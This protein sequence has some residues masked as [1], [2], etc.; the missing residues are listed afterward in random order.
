MPHEP[1]AVR[2]PARSGV[3]LVPVW[4]Y[5]FVSEFLE[6]GLPTL[7]APGNLPTV[8]RELPFRVVALTGEENEALIRSHPAWERLEKICRA[9]I[10]SIDDLI[11]E[12]NH[13][14]T[15]TLALARA[16]KSYGPNVV[17][18]CFV[19][20]M[21]D[22]LMAD[23]SL[24]T[25]MREFQNGASAIF[26]GN[27]Q[28]IA[29]DAI[30]SLR[31]SI[32]L[33]SS[34]LAV[35][36]REL[37][38]WA[39]GYLHPATL[40]NFV[41][42]GLSHNSYTSRLFW[43]VD[44][45]TIIGRFYLMHPI[46]V[47]PE[48][49]DFEIGSSF[50]YSFVPEMCPAGPVSF[51]VDSDRYLVVELQRRHH[52]YDNLLPGPIGE[53]E[54]A[55]QLSEWATAQHRENVAHTLV[56]H[57]AD[58]PAGLTDAIAEADRY[59]ARIGDL[60]SPQPQP[61]RGH[62]YWVG[63]LAVNRMRTGR[64]LSRED[65][66]FLLGEEQPP[67]GLRRL[68]LTLRA[69]MFGTLPKVTRLHPRWPDYRLLNG[70]LE[71]AIANGD[72][73]LL[74]AEAPRAF[75]QWLSG[76][77]ADVATVEIN[78]LL[79]ASPAKYLALF[80]PIAGEFATCVIMLPEPL[81]HHAGELVGRIAPLLIPGGQISI[82]AT[83]E[84]P[85]AKAAGFAKTFAAQSAQ[86][87]TLSTWVADTL[88]VPTTRTRLVTYRALRWFADKASQ[89]RRM[90]PAMVMMM[91]ACV[92]PLALL[93]RWTN[94]A[95]KAS[96]SPSRWSSSILVQLRCA[97]EETGAQWARLAARR[98]GHA[99]DKPAEPVAAQ[100]GPTLAAAEP[101]DS[102]RADR[103]AKYNF[104]GELLA[105][106]ADVAAYGCVDALGS[107][108]VLDKVRK[109]SVYDPDP[110]R[111]GELS[112]KII[113]PWRF[114][115]HVHDILD[116]PLP[117]VHDA[118]YNLDMLEYVSPGDEDRYLG[119]LS[120]SLARRQDILIVGLALCGVDDDAA[121]SDAGSSLGELGFAAV[122]RRPFGLL[123][124]DGPG[125]SLG[126]LNGLARHR[127]TSAGVKALLEHHFDTVSLFSLNAGIVQAG[128]G[129]PGDYL[130]ALCSSKKH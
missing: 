59:V 12:S 87:L 101:T 78:Q 79:S 39:L 30:P 3:I 95:L 19:L 29:E 34:T 118:I 123:R 23:G 82:F 86:L 130:L 105:S 103:V 128:A 69:V 5:R 26:A 116:E 36:K 77:T 38:G 126:A 97:G 40:A 41:N 1:G 90:S 99:G 44:E 84:R 2:L 24:A 43:R 33:R 71:K 56:F 10:E 60:L 129:N 17:D 80:G 81:F 54:L 73:L 14:A 47:R 83:N 122:H 8:A 72:R 108:M 11:T 96:R 66:R 70:V 37:L 35:S 18:T 16:I 67:R 76:T 15:M 100:A 51:L 55:K 58:E 61:H 6:F 4:G 92:L 75:S 9:D 50:D 113:D 111:I 125:T 27:F 63:S 7:L 52:E 42:S 46:G 98:I 53:T 109:L 74:A 28:I 85:F 117:V 25:V 57:A 88:Y 65:W 13:S 104:V 107:K 49:A 112:Q 102:D 124:G 119:N 93:T 91:L 120:R 68:A 48:T 62:H 21:S 64:A 121:A 106:R 22:Y 31:R 115:A 20:W 45:Q 89:S 110:S 32:D 114:G 127:R 94:V